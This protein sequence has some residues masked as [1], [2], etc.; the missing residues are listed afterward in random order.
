ME[1]QTKVELFGENWKEIERKKIADE[2]ELE[3]G[4]DSV[5]KVYDSK[6]LYDFFNPILFYKDPDNKPLNMDFEKFSESEAKYKYALEQLNLRLQELKLN[7]DENPE[8][9]ALENFEKK[10]S[11]LS[12]DGITESDNDLPLEEKRDLD[13]TGRL[14]ESSIKV[15][16]P[17]SRAKGKINQIVSTYFNRFIPM[18]N[19]HICTCCGIAKILNEYYVVYNITCCNRIDDNG[20]YHMWVC[21]N[22][23]QKLFNYYYSVTSNKNAELA[24]QFLCASLNLYWD[25]DLYYRAKS[26]FEDNNRKGTI[27][28]SYIKEINKTAVGLTFMDSPFIA[29]EQ[30]NSTNRTVNS[31]IDEAPFD[32]SQEDAKNKKD[33]VHIFGY[34]PFEFEENDD[35]K[36][37]L[38]A[39]LVSIIDEDIQQDYVKLQSAFTIVKSFNKVRQL[40]KRAHLLEQN[41]A[42]LREQK[43]I[44]DLKAKELKAISDFSRDSGFSERFKTRQSQGQTSFTGI[45]KT[46]NEKKFENELANKYDIETSSTIQAAADASFKAIFNQLNLSE[47]EAFK[48]A[49]DQLEE[50]RKVKKENERLQET[51]RL[52]KYELS[53]LKLKEKAREKGMAVDGN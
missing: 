6:D 31:K 53:E 38:Y 1:I 20:S 37:I 42:S 8:L 23:V 32:W 17:I 10:E 26:N 15:D 36:K 47:A 46:M 52:T 7:K 25:V 4:E 49:A 28:G 51:L 48:L 33:I 34:D 50:L 14:L 13:D 40:D 9:K 3:F 16:T 5:P 21:K 11:A 24:M 27:A 44:A 12:Q 18:Y 2:L 30:Y 41:D 39:D 35:E 45:M 43:D 22:C 19:K 29:D